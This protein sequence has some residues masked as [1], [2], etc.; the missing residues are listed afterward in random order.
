M[1]LHFAL[2]YNCTVFA[3]DENAFI[4]VK[5]D[6]YKNKEKEIVKIEGINYTYNYF[7]DND[8]NRTI[9]ITNSF[10]ESVDIISYDNDLGEIILNGE[11]ISE[12]ILEENGEAE[13]ATREA[14]YSYLGSRS[15]RISW[16]KAAVAATVAGAIAVAVG[17]IGGA[18]VIAAM[19]IAALGALA[20]TAGG[21]V[22]K[23][24]VYSLKAGSFT[25]YKY[26]WSFTASTGDKYGNYT[27]YI[28][29]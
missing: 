9:K 17:N 13:I 18:A 3:T 20:S 4:T 1:Q 12:M 25:N 22:V 28:T 10:D 8:G 5:G 23:T 24:K 16:G 7:Y 19:G 11:K 15:K 2:F 6:I 26:V 21:G 27:S 29:V 14:N